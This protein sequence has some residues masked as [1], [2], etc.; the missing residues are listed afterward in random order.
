M[1]TMRNIDWHL[2]GN[3]IVNT[4]KKTITNEGT[5]VLKEK[6]NIKCFQWEM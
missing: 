5:P 1:S 4:E 3:I 6:H 2:K